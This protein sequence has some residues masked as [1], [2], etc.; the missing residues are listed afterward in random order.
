MIGVMFHSANRVSAALKA[1]CYG[2][3]LWTAA[4]LLFIIGFIF[5]KG[6]PHLNRELFSITYTSE[7]AALLPALLNTLIVTAL[8]LL[9]AAPL[10]I[11]SALFLVEYAG[12]KTWFVQAAR[13]TTET[14]S[15]IP[16]IV[17]G[18][19]GFLLF[20]S[21]FKWGYSMVAGA[22]TLAVMILPL[23]M[24]TTEEALKTV[25]LSYREGSFALGAGKLRTIFRIALPAARPGILAGLILAIGRI[26]GETA[27]LIYTAGTVARVSADLMSS[28]RTLSV[29]LYEL[30]N[31]GINTGPAYGAALVLLFMVTGINTLSAFIARRTAR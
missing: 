11:G 15:G 23:I 27:A 1:L 18:L 6:L 20:V 28:G 22:A 17:Y 25:P 30:W 7:N 29:H 8:A 4:A 13:L 5:I 3:A 14:L 21:A 2:A 19:F 16:S 24:R 12:E 9:I 31:E 26:A 10:G